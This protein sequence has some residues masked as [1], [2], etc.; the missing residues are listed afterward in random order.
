MYELGKRPEEVLALVQGLDKEGLL[1]IILQRK[2]KIRLAAHI[3]LEQALDAMKVC[4]L[5][6]GIGHDELVVIASFFP[7]P[8][9]V[10]ESLDMTG[11]ENLPK[12]IADYHEARYAGVNLMPRRG[13]EILVED[14]AQSL[15]LNPYDVERV[16]ENCYKIMRGGRTIFT[17]PKLYR[18]HLRSLFPQRVSGQTKE[19][20]KQQAVDVNRWIEN[21][22]LNSMVHSEQN[23]V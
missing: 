7:L 1:G 16:F 13:T 4:T 8:A 2:G 5:E 14:A 6:P 23:K 19:Y 20:L 17:I 21:Q 12:N 11:W 18:S 15:K 3:S 10:H 9:E 22:I